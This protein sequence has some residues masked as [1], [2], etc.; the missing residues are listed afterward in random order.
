MFS[1]D[2][3]KIALVLL[4]REINKNNL[5][6]RV[7]LFMQVHDQIDSICVDALVDYWNQVVKVVMEYAAEICLKN[8]LLKTDVEVSKLW[9]K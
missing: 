6:D 3:T 1:A 5:R 8:K 4:R 2:M 9:K 7:K